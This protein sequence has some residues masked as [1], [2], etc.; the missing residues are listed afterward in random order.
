MI[1]PRPIDG[2][3]LTEQANHQSELLWNPR[4]QVKIFTSCFLLIN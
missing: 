1:D 3:V 4:G 2:S